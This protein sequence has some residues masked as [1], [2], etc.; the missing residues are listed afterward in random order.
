M[1]S[2]G[3]ILIYIPIV[4]KWES[5]FPHSHANTIKLWNFLTVQ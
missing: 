4:S 3:I 2:L 1:P 5:V